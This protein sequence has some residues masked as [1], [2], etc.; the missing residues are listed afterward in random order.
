M[1]GVTTRAT[2]GVDYVM[3]PAR[4]W[5]KGVMVTL[6]RRRDCCDAD[7]EGHNYDNFGTTSNDT[8]TRKQESTFKAVVVRVVMRRC[9][10]KGE[11]T[12]MMTT[13]NDNYFD[14][15]VEC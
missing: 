6:T 11:E 13:L 10:R 3:L 8:S 15:Q 1:R 2:R 14:N 9:C 7:R 5:A 4:D 12:M